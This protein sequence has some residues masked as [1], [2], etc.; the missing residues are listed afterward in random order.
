MTGEPHHDAGDGAGGP[1]AAH[2][3]LRTWLRAITDIAGAVTQ[4]RPLS[5]LL[6]LLARSACELMGY[7]FCAV[8][9]ANESEGMLQICGSYGLSAEYA[10]EV[11][12]SLSFRM[13]PQSS[14]ETPS[15]R[16]FVSGQPVA[17]EDVLADPTFRPWGRIAK[18]QG[19]GA[20][21]AVPLMVNGRAVGTL[22]GYRSRPYRFPQDEVLLLGALANLAGTAIET[23]R[24]RDNELETIGELET[25]NS[26][27]QAQARLLKQAEEIHRRLTVV[28]LGSGGVEALVSVLAGLVDRPVLVE[29]AAFGVL[30]VAAH[31]GLTVDAPPPTVR[32]EFDLPPD[33]EGRLVDVPSWP[34]ATPDAPRVSAPIFLDD[35]LVA[36]FWMPG[37][38][39]DLGPL[40]RRAVEHAVVVIALQLIRERT[41]LDVEW[42]LRG[43]LLGELL[44]DSPSDSVTLLPRARHLGHDLTRPHAV[45]VV[46]T[47]PTDGDP[48]SSGG[49]DSRRVLRLVRTSMRSSTSIPLAT[50]SGEYVVALWPAPG[51]CGEPTP[52]EAADAIRRN[53]SRASSS[54]RVSVA[55]GEPCEDIRAYAKAFRMQRGALELARLQGHRDRTI[56]L[57]RMGFYGLLLQLDEPSVLSQFAQ[58]TL[59]P[60]RA[61]D[62]ARQTDLVGTLQTYLAHDLN[63]ARTAAAL[64][65]HPNTVALRLKR[66]ES[67]L[68]LVLARPESLLH[69]KAALMADDVLRLGRH[70]PS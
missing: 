20:L 15:S 11:G 69:L 50:I 66:I 30:A 65:V 58:E 12:R 22:N 41:A 32:S 52:E 29:D 6:D 19:I 62:A 49:S 23:A 1:A 68:G 51:D 60:L 46:R 39:E 53:W 21:I 33:V 37:R 7:D 54:T 4:H 59:A 27:L 61:Y 10:S 31:E 44:S 5:A 36:R 13:G 64:F 55:V 24:L 56:T 14:A 26:S 2:G 17:V 35:D 28:A 34:G 42:T 8:L 45:L 16:A 18:Q 57:P 63:T 67:L 48:A 9:L 70:G 38:V 43:D 47:D 40:Q 25:L 3:E